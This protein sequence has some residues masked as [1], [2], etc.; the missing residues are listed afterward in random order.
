MKLGS[1]AGYASSFDRHMAPETRRRLYDD[2]YE[3]TAAALAKGLEL[4]LGAAK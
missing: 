1:G 3:T 2:G 4:R